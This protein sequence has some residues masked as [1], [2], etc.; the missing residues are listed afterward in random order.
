VYFLQSHLGQVMALLL[1]I[2]LGAWWAHHAT[3]RMN[4]APRPA[5]PE[6]ARTSRA[7]K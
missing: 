1:I 2:T 3:K 6:I 7:T 5:N 4:R